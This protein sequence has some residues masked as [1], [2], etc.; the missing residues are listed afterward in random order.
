[1][2]GY[3][4]RVVTR[5]FAILSFAALCGFASA[6]AQPIGSG[7]LDG[8]DIAW[9]YN[10]PGVTLEQYR[11]DEIS[12]A[13]RTGGQ[14]FNNAH[15]QA[16]QNL[17]LAIMSASVAPGQHNAERDNCMIVMGY[18][19]F[20]ISP[21]NQREFVQRLES[22]G[23]EELRRHVS[24]ASPPEGALIMEWR[25][26][27]L[28]AGTSVRAAGDLGGPTPTALLP[29]LAAF[30]AP[31]YAR[32]RTVREFSAGDARD[33]ALATIALSISAADGDRGTWN[34]HVLLF[35]RIDP[36]TGNAPLVRNHPTFINLGQWDR[37]REPE[38]LQIFQAPPGR[39]ALWRSFDFPRFT[40]FCL[41]TIA[42]DVRAGDVVYAGSWQTRRAGPI[43]VSWGNLDATKTALQ[44][45]I[46]P[47]AS[48]MQPATFQN[49]AQLP[50]GVT[51]AGGT[52]LYGI[53]L[54]VAGRE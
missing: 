54:P 27:F 37:D 51:A 39:Y 17:F 38:R 3:T 19:R 53:E 30:G 14:R 26:G 13:A 29:E 48:S 50:C 21:G 6:H 23:D 34:K 47:A 49:G 45:M 9:F 46:G 28:D 18:R 15:A 2:N 24:E 44:A 33:P 16:G 35:L 20:V 22:G 12:C 4:A 52:R 42:F 8:D 36:E 32:D 1:M 31:R 5:I 11:A 7:D 43:S 10:K 41:R 40:D 25:N